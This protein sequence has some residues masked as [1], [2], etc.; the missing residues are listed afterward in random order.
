MLNGTINP[1]CGS[2]FLQIP[3]W[4]SLEWAIAPFTSISEALFYSVKKTGLSKRV[5]EL[6]T[7]ECGHSF[8]SIKQRR[9]PLCDSVTSKFS[10]GTMKPCV[11]GLYILVTKWHT[12]WSW[13]TDGEEKNCFIRLWNEIY[14]RFNI[15]NL[16]E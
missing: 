11:L 4:H 16:W 5:P 7:W 1:S 15:Q 9:L 2:L 13:L 10:G 8:K 3:P 12:S 14:D 6:V